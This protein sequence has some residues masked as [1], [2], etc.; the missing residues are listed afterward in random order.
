MNILLINL[1]HH[2]SQ[3]AFL[4]KSNAQLFHLQKHFLPKPKIHPRLC[5]RLYIDMK[6]K[7]ITDEN[8]K[9]EY[10]RS[11]NYYELN[12]EAL[13][14]EKKVLLSNF[15]KKDADLN[16]LYN[17]LK[18]YENSYLYRIFKKITKSNK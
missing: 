3:N 4:P 13:E 11:K 15:I 14:E 6:K 2:S 16:Y 1:S 10:E 8:L 17:K 7:F 5:E 9:Y 18:Q 12:M